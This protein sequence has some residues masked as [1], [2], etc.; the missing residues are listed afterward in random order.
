MGF[1]PA[2]ARRRIRPGAHVPT[3]RQFGSVPFMTFLPAS[4]CQ[5]GWRLLGPSPA[6]DVVVGLGAWALSNVRVVGVYSGNAVG[7]LGPG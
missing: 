5:C 3:P 2:E 7:N 4:H 1:G 6:A